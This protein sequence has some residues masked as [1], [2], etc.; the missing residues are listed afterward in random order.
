MT[1]IITTSFGQLQRLAQSIT[2][3]AI[4][5]AAS[6]MKTDEGE[7]EAGK[8]DSESKIYKAVLRLLHF[9][10]HKA[11]LQLLVLKVYGNE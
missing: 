4:S 2:D 10:N 8:E 7:D 9:T 6:S 11:K 1:S 3:D 5:C